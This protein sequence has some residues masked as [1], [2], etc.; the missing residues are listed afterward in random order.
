MFQQE[1][2]LAGP[3]DYTYREVWKRASVSVLPRC[4][5]HALCVFR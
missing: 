5:A 4:L 3:E 1:Y 2:D